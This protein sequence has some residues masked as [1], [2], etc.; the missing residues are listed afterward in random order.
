MA[1]DLTTG[2]AWA[3]ASG[4]AGIAE[5][6]AGATAEQVAVIDALRRHLLRIDADEAATIEAWGPDEV[7]EALPAT[8]E[9][10]IFLRMGII[11]ELCRHPASDEQLRLV[12]TY[13]EALGVGADQ[14]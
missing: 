14:L 11:V 1:F 12:E 7:A 8:G 2:V 4:L 10:R 9:R 6:D 13:G 5:V 3:M